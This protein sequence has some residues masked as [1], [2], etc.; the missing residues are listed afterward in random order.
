MINAKDL[1]KQRALQM[2]A[3]KKDDS[4]ILKNLIPVLGK[5]LSP[6]Q[7]VTLDISSPPNSKAAEHYSKVCA[8]LLLF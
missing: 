2:N 1:M 4:T 5:G 6:G 3:S 8:I 7:T